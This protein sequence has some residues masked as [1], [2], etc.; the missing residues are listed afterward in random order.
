[1]AYNV[2]FIIVYN[3]PK[4]DVGFYVALN[5]W[6]NSWMLPSQKRGVKDW[7]YIDGGLECQ[8][9]RMRRTIQSVTWYTEQQNRRL[10]P[11]FKFELPAL[12]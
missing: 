11:T 3:N 2:F 8:L 4:F 6:R 9:R 7:F 5:I 1:M 12:R 10:M